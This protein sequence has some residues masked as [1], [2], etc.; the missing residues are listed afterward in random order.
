MKRGCFLSVFLGLTVII[1]LSIVLWRNYKDD[2]LEYVK[3]YAINT[4]K[5]D[6]AEK[7]S[8][9]KDSTNVDSLKSILQVYL[10][11]I[12]DDKD[13]KIDMAGGFIGQ[14]SQIIKDGIVDSLE[15][16][17]ITKLLQTELSGKNERSKEDGN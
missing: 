3:T 11:K 6:M 9:V 17:E 15:I 13:I 1:A 16:S 14:T 2:A 4:V 7:F 10:N 5:S 12:H 8:H